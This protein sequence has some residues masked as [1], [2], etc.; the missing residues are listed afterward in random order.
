MS[1]DK[2]LEAWQKR[3]EAKQ[4][5]IDTNGKLIEEPYRDE[6]KR[7]PATRATVL[8]ESVLHTIIAEKL[9]K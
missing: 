8:A 9:E 2:L 6:V 1:L 3:S 7:T 5:Y 4:Q